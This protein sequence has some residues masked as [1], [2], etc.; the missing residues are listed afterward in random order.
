MRCFPPW[1][2]NE[3][4]DGKLR[5][6]KKTA[7]PPELR[8]QLVVQDEDWMAFFSGRGALG[9]GNH[10]ENQGKG[11]ADNVTLWLSEGSQLPALQAQLRL[12]QIEAQKE[13]RNDRIPAP[14]E[15][16]QKSLFQ[17]PFARKSRMA[18]ALRS[19]VPTFLLP[20][21]K[22]P[23]GHNPGHTRR[24]ARRWPHTTTQISSGKPGKFPARNFAVQLESQTTGV[25]I[26]EQ[27]WAEHFK[28]LRQGTGCH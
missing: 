22:P 12:G 19:C 2:V 16:L 14:P 3:A 10:C 21:G 13:Q 8:L 1:P 26:V 27:Q 18:L 28:L 4:N 20:D 7:V 9:T 11:T 25:Q 5:V 24:N 23:V 15:T 17:S 6:L